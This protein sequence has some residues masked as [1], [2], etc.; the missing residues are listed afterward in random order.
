MIETRSSVLSDLP[1]SN[2]I[3]LSGSSNT[4]SADVENPPIKKAQ[5]GMTI[6]IQV[7]LL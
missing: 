5:H 3:Q 6:T 2:H 7:Q 1:A 4:G